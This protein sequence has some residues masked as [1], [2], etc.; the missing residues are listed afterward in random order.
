LNPQVA[1]DIEKHWQDKLCGR[2]PVAAV[3]VR[4]SDK[5]IELKDLPKVNQQYEQEITKLIASQ[6]ELTIFLLTD[7]ESVLEQFKERYGTRLVYTQSIRTSSDVGVHMQGHPGREIGMEVLRD[8]YLAA[9]CDY[10]L[11]NGFS[12]VSTTVSHLKDWEPGKYSLIGGNMLL[13]WNFVLHDR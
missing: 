9:R 12:N 6:R 13:R 3:H 7:S 2:R 4:G 10:F 11:G 8:V 5:L 1:L